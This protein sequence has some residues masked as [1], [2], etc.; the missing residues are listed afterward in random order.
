MTSING[1]E[2]DQSDFHDNMSRTS[3]GEVDHNKVRSCANV[4]GFV[5]GFVKERG[6]G[7]GH[8][9]SSVHLEIVGSVGAGATGN[10]ATPFE[11]DGTTA[12]FFKIFKL[13]DRNRIAGEERM[14]LIENLPN[15]TGTLVPEQRQTDLDHVKV[16]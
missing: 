4:G 8:E 12:A 2:P 13:M 10:R 15:V 14:K 16:N 5:G 3:E 1:D 11:E 6:Y 9:Y 7:K